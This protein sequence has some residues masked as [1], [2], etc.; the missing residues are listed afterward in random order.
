LEQVFGNVVE[1]LG[2]LCLGIDGVGARARLA[3]AAWQEGE[4]GTG[5]ESGK[6]LPARDGRVG[7]KSFRVSIIPGTRKR[8]R[9]AFYVLCKKR[10]DPFFD[11]AGRLA[12]LNRRPA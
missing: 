3:A 4:R 6:S 12:Q 9:D 5:R 1:Q 11:E 2:H 7:H 8:D 10:P